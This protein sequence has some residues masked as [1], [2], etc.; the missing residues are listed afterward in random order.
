MPKNLTEISAQA[1]YFLGAFFEKSARIRAPP[2]LDHTHRI[3]KI[4][5]FAQIKSAFCTT[6]KSTFLLQSRRHAPPVLFFA[7]IAPCCEE[8]PTAKLR[9]GS[10]RVHISI[11]KD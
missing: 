2:H 5:R 6:Q 4:R 11:H 1:A 7:M 8:I 10:V 3:L 9:T